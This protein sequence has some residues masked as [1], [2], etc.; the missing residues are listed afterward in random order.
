MMRASWPDVRLSAPLPD[1]GMDWLVRLPAGRTLDVAGALAVQAHQLKT[2][3]DGS[4]YLPVVGGPRLDQLAAT[5]QRALLAGVE[6]QAQ[7][8]A[9]LYGVDLRE[10]HR[11]IAHS[12]GVPSAVVIPRAYEIDDLTYAIIWAVTSLDDALLADDSALDQRRRQFREFEQ[13]PV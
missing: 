12:P 9:R 7:Q 4:V 6:E 13:L 11:K 2:A 1:Q 8:A 5:S 10:A 3:A